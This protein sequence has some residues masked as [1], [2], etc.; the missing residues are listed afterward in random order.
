MSAQQRPHVARQG[1]HAATHGQQQQQ[2][3]AMMDAM[4]TTLPMISAMAVP[5]SSTWYS[6]SWMSCEELSKGDLPAFT[7]STR[8]QKNNNKAFRKKLS[9]RNEKKSVFAIAD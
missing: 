5:D 3:T 2:M 8:K 7:S 1:K 4:T 9:I 6:D